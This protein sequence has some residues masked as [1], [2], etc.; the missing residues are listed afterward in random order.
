M[1]SFWEQQSFL[2]YD[3]IVIGSGIVGLSTAIAIKEFHAKASVLVLERGIF[4]TGAS[5]KNAGFACIG[6]LTE[7]LS[8]LNAYDSDTVLQLVEKRQQ[9]LQK[10]R[11]R[12]GDKSIDYR[13][14]GSYEL[15]SDNELPALEHLEAINDLLF[16]LLQTAAFSTVSHLVP[17]FGFDKGYVKALISNNCEG[18]LDTGKMMNSLL[19]YAQ[20]KGVTV[21]NGAMVNQVEDDGETVAVNVCPPGSTENILFKAGSVAICTNAF[22]AS[23]LPQ[24]ELTP[25]RGQ[26]L[27]TKPIQHLRFKGIFHFDEGYYYFRNFE[28]RVIFGGGRNLDF[29]KESTTDFSLNDSI[30]QELKKRLQEVI[31]PDTPFEVAH[32]WTGIMAFG[33]SKA[34]LLKK[35]SKNVGI[36]VRLGGMGVAIGSQLGEDLA[37]LLYKG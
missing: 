28:N 25:G 35:I 37:H 17:K 31:L 19:L 6:S 27:V 11:S 22:T 20:E 36:G 23:L 33:K 3:Y 34:P 14:E 7:L 30:Q 32:R 16:P 8:D 15:I 13:E 29:E 21:I 18:Q 9:G 1:L 12:L 10:L 5:T 24:I 26:V 4:P 2:Q